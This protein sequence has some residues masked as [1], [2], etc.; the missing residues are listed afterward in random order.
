MAPLTTITFLFAISADLVYAAHAG[1]HVQ[2]PWMTRGRPSIDR[3]VPFCGMYS[4][5]SLSLARP[6]GLIPGRGDIA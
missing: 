5:L 6:R 4:Y 1:F 2:F 3:Y